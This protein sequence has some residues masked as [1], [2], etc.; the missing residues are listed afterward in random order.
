MHIIEINFICCFLLFYE[1]TGK[2]LN[3][4]LTYCI[5]IGEYFGYL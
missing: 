3:C 4:V 5:A 1:T 2:Q